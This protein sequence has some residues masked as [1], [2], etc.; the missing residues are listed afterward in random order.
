MK[1]VQGEGG[2]CGGSQGSGEQGWLW[3]IAAVPGQQLACYSQPVVPLS[4]GYWGVW[5][6]EQGI[7]LKRKLR[8]C[9]SLL[10]S[11]CLPA[12]LCETDRTTVLSEVGQC[13]ERGLEGHI[14]GYAYMCCVFS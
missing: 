1:G 14:V 5:A 4:L 7:Y 8:I 12:N 13:A 9:L 6:G 10:I 3:V 2:Q 11:F